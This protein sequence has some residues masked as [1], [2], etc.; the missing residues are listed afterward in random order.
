MKE[1]K[2]KSI[3][4][5][6]RFDKFLKK[7]LRE[8]SSGFIYKM[9]RKKNII[10][11]GKKADGSEILNDGDSIKMFFSDQTFDKFTGKTSAN[12]MDNHTLTSKIANSNM[13]KN[14]AD[15]KGIDVYTQ[16]GIKCI[17][18]KQYKVPIIYENNDLIFFNKPAGLLSQKSKPEDISLVDILTEYLKSTSE[19]ADAASGFRPGICNRLDRNTSGIVAAGK[20]VRGLQALSE[21]IKNR[22]VKKLYTCIVEGRVIKGEHMSGYLIK[23]SNDNIVSLSQK[24]VEGAVKIETAYEPVSEMMVSGRAYTRL[25]VE[26]IT[27]KTHQIRAHMAY[28]GH[29]IAG[30]GK[31]G[32]KTK[33]ECGY[34][35]LH[36][37]N[38]VFDNMDGVLKPLSGMSIEAAVPENFKIKNS[39]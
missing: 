9:L 6:Q 18:F 34:Q 20:S 14:D 23:N 4:A 22:S 12:D 15:N 8:A 3:E 28:T 16:D 37:K 39:R 38:L 31:Y 17:S 2:V 36:A 7:Y 35:L 19:D 32:S 30:D 10:L 24:P 27:G 29:P 1:I 21:V 13:S 25:S 5:G 33:T 11:N 26:L